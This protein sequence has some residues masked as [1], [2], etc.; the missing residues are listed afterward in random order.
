VSSLVNPSVPEETEQEYK[1]YIEHPQHLQLAVYSESSTEMDEQ[2]SEYVGYVNGHDLYNSSNF[3]AKS[4]NFDGKTVY[5][6]N[7]KA[8]VDAESEREEMNFFEDWCTIP[9]D[10]LTVREDEVYQKKY[11]AYLRSVGGLW[12]LGGGQGEHGRNRERDG[13]R[14]SLDNGRGYI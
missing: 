4:N 11:K 1:R 2:G 6:Y 7:K 3:G 12:I 9:E 14:G 8:F 10:P 13:M 5:N